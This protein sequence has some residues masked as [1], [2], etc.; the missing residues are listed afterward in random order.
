MPIKTSKLILYVTFMAVIAQFGSDNF[1]PSLPAM[2]E[3]FNVS[4]HTTQY[5]VSLYLLGMSL[6]Q[7]VYGPLSD[8]FGRKKA[9]VSGYIVFAL[10]G[11]I[12]SF[13]YDIHW[14]LLGRFI[15]GAGIACTGLFR[16]IM[17]D[18]YEGKA[19]AR[20]GSIITIAA[21]MTPPLAPITGGYLQDLFGWRAS[22]FLL[23]VMGL[24]GFIL[25]S[26][27]FPESLHPERRH[28][29]SLK[30]ILKSYS[31][32]FKDK[33]FVGYAACAG[34]SLGMIFGYL[35]VSAFLF[36]HQLGLTPVQ[37][38]WLA[39]FGIFFMPTGAFLNNYFAGTFNAFQ[40]TV[41]AVL[42]VLTGSLMMLTFALF[43]IMN[44]YVILIPLF[45]TFIGIGF[46]F[47]NSFSQAFQ[48]FGHIAGVAGAAY[49]ALQMF[50]S[51]IATSVA[52][53]LPSETQLPLALYFIACSL[54]MLLALMCTK[55]T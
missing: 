45:I 36:Q 17:R 28:R 8:V 13:A 25:F 10:G 12:C 39:I 46:I 51:S 1:L 14:L 54:C 53:I 42:L 33:N 9:L 31:E 15:Q 11:V 43:G 35:S 2:A 4:K 48:N 38:G 49:G 5:S 20:L 22:F 26:W 27:S 44:V 6:F 23:T 16:S 30:N 3:Y 52:A 21:T 47:P 40:L 24:I 18:L 32:C 19:L 29:F 34:L 41:F 50:L 55:K 37:Y 7:F